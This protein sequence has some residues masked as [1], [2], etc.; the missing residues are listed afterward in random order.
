MMFER[1]L[2]LITDIIDYQSIQKIIN[3]NY[4]VLIYTISFAIT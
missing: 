4:S 1:N 2:K 3:K